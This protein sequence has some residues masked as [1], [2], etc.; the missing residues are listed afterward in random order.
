LQHGQPRETLDIDPQRIAVMGDSAGANLALGT[1]LAL[2]DAGE[3]LLRGAVL[4]YGAYSL[5]LN[6]ASVRDFGGGAYF[7]GTAEI[8]R[9]WHDYLPNAADRKNR[10][11]VP[12]LADLGN[13]PSLYVAA[14]EFDPLRDDSQRLAERAKAAG[15]ELEFRLWKEMVH[16][17]ISLMG[18]VDYMG[19]EVDRIGEF[20]RRVTGAR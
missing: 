11:A 17:S 19:S 15:T 7:L 9:Y 12:M 14:C 6:T 10:L 8:K 4:A 3:H 13:L 1:C 18:W 5:N 2:R 20:L 16:G